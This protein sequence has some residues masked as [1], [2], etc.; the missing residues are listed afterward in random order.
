MKKGIVCQVGY[1]QKLYRD[2]WSTEHKTQH[3]KLY[4]EHLI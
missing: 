4:C 1:L 3:T 2:A